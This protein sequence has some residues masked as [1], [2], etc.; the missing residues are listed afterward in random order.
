MTADLLT[1]LLRRDGPA[2]SGD[3]VR[4]MQDHGLSGSAAR[5]RLSRRAPNVSVLTGLTFPKRARFF[6]HKDDYRRERYWTALVAAISQS[7]PAYGAA[8]G[9]LRAHGGIVPLHYFAIVTGA[10]IRQRKQ[11]GVDAVFSRLRHIGLIEEVFVDELP[12]VRLAAGGWLGGRDQDVA[13]RLLVQRIMLLAVADWARKLN[14]GSYNK[15]AVRDLNEALPTFGTHAF[16][17]CGPSYIAPMIRRDASGLPKPGFLVCDAFVGKLDETGIA[18]FLRKCASSAAIRNLPPFLPV[19]IAEAFTP[20]AFN[21]ARSR[22]IITATPF[23]LFGREIAEGL[24]ALLQTLE[25]ASAIAAEKPE[26]VSDLFSRLGQIE[27]AAVNLRGALFELVVGH[28]VH[29]E[30]QGSIDVGK[31]VSLIGEPAV[32]VDVYLAS[33]NRVRVIECK[34]YGP[35]Q[36]VGERE[37]SRW[38][39]EKVPKLRKSLQREPRHEGCRFSF[40]FWTSGDYSHEAQALANTAN[41]RTEKYEMLF[42][43]GSA[44]RQR[45]RDANLTGL[46]KVFDE[47][48]A[49]HPLTKI[50]K[51]NAAT[52]KPLVDVAAAACEDATNTLERAATAEA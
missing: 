4:K 10:P 40:E 41:E 20:E 5:Q 45:L 32:E 18:A 46:V 42:L 25:R 12:C 48:Y 28:V 50:E 33:S 24:S 52:L 51:K 30:S 3:L 47:H 19:V 37:L 23:N 29:Q 1:V 31:K 11:I 14:I 13:H 15:I 9:A 27:G 38:V 49:K 26:V 8:E 16:D 21:L 35:N 2:L 6:Y 36:Q 34:G 22:G 43:D 17:L 7:S 39:N 44:V